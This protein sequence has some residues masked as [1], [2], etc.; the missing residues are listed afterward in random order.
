MYQ[1]CFYSERDGNVELYDTNIE[2]ESNK[3]DEIKRKLKSYYSKNNL[4]L[5]KKDYNLKSEIDCKEYPTYMA[6][7]PDKKLPA[8]RIEFSNNFMVNHIVI[9]NN[10]IYVS[11]NGEW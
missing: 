2:L 4:I 8:T 10:K 11:F 9:F 1:N 7:Y 6:Y 5:E 3:P